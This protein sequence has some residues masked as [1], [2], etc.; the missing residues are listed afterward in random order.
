M[1]IT[2]PGASETNCAPPNTLKTPTSSNAGGVSE[3]N[4]PLVCRS[5]EIPWA[6][7]A[8][9]IR[10]TLAEGL[11]VYQVPSQSPPCSG[12]SVDVV[13]LLEKLTLTEPDCS[14]TPQ[15]SLTKTPSLMPKPVAPSKASSGAVRI[16]CNLVGVQTGASARSPA[17]TLL[18]GVAVEEVPPVLLTITLTVTRRTRPSSNCK[19]TIPV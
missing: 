11:C 3:A 16:G 2:S 18:P 5:P 14:G 1:E 7:T 13:S 10:F 15:S 6:S 8:W 17:R 12:C 19:V 9:T 4:E